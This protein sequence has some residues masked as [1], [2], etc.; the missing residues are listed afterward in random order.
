MISYRLMRYVFYIL[1]A[2]GVVSLS[3][4]LRHA[5]GIPPSKKQDFAVGF[6]ISGS[7]V[8]IAFF[9]ISK[10]FELLASTIAFGLS[11]WFVHD[12]L[13]YGFSRWKKNYSE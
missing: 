12:W 1:L 3:L 11:L 7:L 4:F 8:V 9:P 6:T 5:L 2:G 13:F 10:S